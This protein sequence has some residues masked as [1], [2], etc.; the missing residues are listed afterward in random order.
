MDKSKEESQEYNSGSDE[1]NSSN[2][3]DNSPE[4]EDSSENEPDQCAKDEQSEKQPVQNEISSTY[5]VHYSHYPPDIHLL[6]LRKVVFKSLEVSL[7]NSRDLKS[8]L[9][10]VDN[11]LKK[12]GT[13]EKS[14]KNIKNIGV[15][16]NDLEK[17]IN[18]VEKVISNAEIN[19]ADK[20]QKKV[21]P[22]LKVVDEKLKEEGLFNLE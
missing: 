18:L 2:Q 8:L 20:L 19:I 3:S 13:I 5:D 1:D 7:A 6:A 12:I 14:S 11:V 4:S 22:H 9:N 17:S 21:L 15:V 16:I 10:E